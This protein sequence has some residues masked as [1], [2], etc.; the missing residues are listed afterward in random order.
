MKFLTVRDLRG[1]AAEVWRRLPA[2]REL[3]VTN[4]GRPVAILATVSE[5]NLEENLS[6]IRQ[7]RAVAALNKLHHQALEQGLDKLAPD[8]VAAEITAVRRKHRR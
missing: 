4:N 7:A 5:G 8:E 2:E 3:V 6:I 1:K